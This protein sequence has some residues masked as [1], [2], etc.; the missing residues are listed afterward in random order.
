MGR[1]NQDI[2]QSG[3][4]AAA[5]FLKLKGYKIVGSNLRTPFGELDLVARHG[6]YIVFIEVKSRSTDSLGPPSL[7][8]T[9]QKRK[10]IVKNALWYLAGPGRAHSY[11]RIDVVSVK[12][13][14]SRELE[15]IEVIENAVED[16]GY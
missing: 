11:W 13:N 8:V 3:E 5:E 9:W 2:G 10:R 12:L 7:S 15:H 1:E 14:A 6:R 4:K 16:D